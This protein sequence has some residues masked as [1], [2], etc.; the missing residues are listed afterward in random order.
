MNEDMIQ[1]QQ[2]TRRRTEP[3]DERHAFARLADVLAGLSANATEDNREDAIDALDWLRRH[4]AEGRSLPQS[5]ANAVLVALV[6]SGV[7]MTETED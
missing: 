5:N 2:Q 7:T 1:R 6:T 4:I 3:I